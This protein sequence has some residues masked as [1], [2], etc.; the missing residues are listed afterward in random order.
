M[1]SRDGRTFLGQADVEPDAGL[2]ADEEE[3]SNAES[4]EVA[5]SSSINAILRI[6]AETQQQMLR[7][8][9]TQSSAPKARILAS[10]KIP[11][12]DGAQSTTVRHYREWRKEVAVIKELNGLTDREVAMLLFSQLKGRAKE[13]IEIIEFA[14]FEKG[15]VL[16]LIWKIYDDAFEKMAHQRLDDTNNDWERAHRKPGQPM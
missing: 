10:V 9:T 11:Y 1:A 2:Q 7:H 13:L 6:L 12:F 4:S 16:D 3:R 8:T 14:D 15:N 5:S